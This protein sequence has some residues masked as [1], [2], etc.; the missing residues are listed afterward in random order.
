M[1]LV[2]EIKKDLEK[3]GK[4]R[5]IYA[6]CCFTSSNEK[7]V[8]GKDFNSDMAFEYFQ[9]KVSSGLT[10]RDKKFNDENFTGMIYTHF[11]EYEYFEREDEFF[12]ITDKTCTETYKNGEEVEEHF[13]DY[14]NQISMN[15]KS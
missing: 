1:R 7:N 6:E 8:A 11:K 10:A 14:I 15:K 2:F 13:M 12:L 9:N 3:E 5:N 4:K